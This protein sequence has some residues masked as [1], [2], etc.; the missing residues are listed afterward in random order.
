MTSEDGLIGL[1]TIALPGVAP[2]KMAATADIIIRIRIFMKASSHE[3]EQT[4]WK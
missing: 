2:A 4:G 1:P 3:F